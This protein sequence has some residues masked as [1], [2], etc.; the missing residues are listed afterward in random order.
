MIEYL[1]TFLKEKEGSAPVWVTLAGEPTGSRYL[2]LA[3]DA[4]GVVIAAP[5]TPERGVAHPWTAIISVT[6][7]REAR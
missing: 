4:T 5:A 3:V 2:M 7:D 6:P 1:Q